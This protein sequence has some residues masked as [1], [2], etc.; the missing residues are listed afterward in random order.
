MPPL[1]LTP[2][3]YK[4]KPRNKRSRAPRIV[5]N[6]NNPFQLAI[7]LV[8]ML[9]FVGS[10]IFGQIKDG[11]VYARQ[12]SKAQVWIDRGV[13]LNHE[14][15]ELYREH[16]TFL[17][18]S[19]SKVRSRQ[20]Q[21]LE[22]KLVE[23]T[24]E[25]NE[26]FD[27]VNRCYAALPVRYMRKASVRRPFIVFASECIVAALERGQYEQ[28]RLWF[29]A[30]NLNELMPN[31]REQ[32]IGKGSIHVSVDQYIESVV[33]IPIM[34]DGPKL[35]LCDP[36]RKVEEFPVEM[37]D[38]DPGSYILWATLKNGTFAPY[39][40]LMGHGETLELDLKAP[41]E[42]PESMVYIPGGPFVCGGDYS[43]LYRSHTRD[44]AP[45]F[46]K[47]CE[48]TIGEYL[49]FWSSLEDPK[50]KAAYMS[51]I[52]IGTETFPAW[53]DDGTELDQHVA[54]LNADYPVA[55]ISMDAAEAYCVWLSEKLGQTVRLPT[56]FEW[57]KA[58]R[59]VD[60]RTY[61]WGY[62]YEENGNFAFSCDNER[63]REK[64]PLWAPVGSLRRDVSVFGILDMGGN[65]R[66]LTSTPMPG[67]DGAFQVK[68]GSVALS[69]A[70]LPCA[71]VTQSQMQSVPSDIGFR[72]I[73]ELPELEN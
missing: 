26:C 32:V 22:E 71:S 20:E 29:N 41:D 6:W 11:R 7:V 27:E 45:F 16:Q 55:G 14:A 59:G 35:V 51:R 73:I 36:I 21:A 2:K 17:E 4:P 56:A 58:A 37:G 30:S 70:Y 19:T 69:S 47:R 38:L 18:N 33:L 63:A 65:V 42:V 52:D 64:Y 10:I 61:P 68:G 31:T 25:I 13:L 66:E 48:V 54:P 5:R 50:L 57:E 28:G 44:L 34:S 1:D 62:G 46:M 60:G 72:Y 23:L 43:P 3:K 15:E 9:A 40:F 39:P 8:S 24:K 12:F 53:S 67:M 49:E